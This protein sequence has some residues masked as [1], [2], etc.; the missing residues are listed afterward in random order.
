[1]AGECREIRIAVRVSYP[2][3]GQ[4]DWHEALAEYAEVSAVEVAFYRVDPCLE[5]V[6][7]EDVCAPFTALPIRAASVHMAHAQITK[8]EPS[9]LFWTRRPRL[10]RLCNAA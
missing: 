7:I 8:P 3:L 9:W 2:E 5:R 1:M 4:Y 6:Q 10:P